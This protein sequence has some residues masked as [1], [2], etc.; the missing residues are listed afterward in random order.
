MMAQAEARHLLMRALGMQS[1]FWGMGR[2]TGELYAVL[3]TASEPLTLANI[4]EELG[5]TKGNVS[6]AIRRLEELNMVRR[7][8]HPGD[9]RVFFAANRDFWDIARAFLGRRYQPAFAASFQL[10]EDSLKH[11]EQ[12]GDA[13]VSERILALK[14]FYDGLDQLTELLREMRPAELAS[15]VELAS[16]VVRRGDD[17]ASRNRKE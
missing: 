4:A 1:G 13:F 12:E 14:Q 16:Q 6:V 11:A 9:R 17:D 7:Q 3:Y 5:V 2:I 10:V 15:L 8:Y